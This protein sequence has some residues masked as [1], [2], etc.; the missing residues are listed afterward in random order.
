M[1][2]LL[3]LLSGCG[4]GWIGGADDRTAGLPTSGAGPYERLSRDDLTPASEPRFHDE[5]RASVED[6]S[7]L[8]GGPGLRVWFT[9]ATL[10]PVTSEIQYIEAP[11]LRDLPTREVTVL[12]ASE[13]WEEGIVGSPSVIAD[14]AGGFIMFYE[15]GIA[16]PSIGR[17]VSRDGLT[18]QKDG[19]PLIVGASSPAAVVAYGETWLFATRVAEVGI[20]RAVDGGSGFTFD[21]A[22]V[23]VPRP[24]D[25]DAFDRLTVSDP[26]ALATPT[27]EAG[28]TRIHLWFAGT[29]D[30]PNDAT[31]VGYVASFDGVEWLRFGGTNPML[32]ADATGPTVVLDATGGVMLFAEPVG[33]GLFQLASAEH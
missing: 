6:P 5:N 18:W 31:A 12:E 33:G 14:G 27:L 29:T 26:F 30:M 32:A 4:L 3:F 19:D 23:V 13:A 2:A 20:W 7:M 28:L 15:G 10:D 22:P 11:S 8:V 9:R 24:E 16:M 17:A 25:P 21:A 1:R